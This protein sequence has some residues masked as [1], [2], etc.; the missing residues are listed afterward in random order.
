M[1]TNAAIAIIGE[2]FPVPFTQFVPTVPMGVIGAIINRRFLETPENRARMQKIDRWLA[3]DLAPILIYPIFT[4]VFMTVEPQQQMWLSLFLPILKLFLRYLLWLVIKD[5]PDLV[6]AA[7]CSVGHLYHILF[8]VMCLQN[9][10][11][12]ETYA[13]VV[14]VNIL[15]MLLNCR[16]I[17]KDAYELRRVAEQVEDLDQLGVKGIVSIVSLIALQEQISR[18][19]HRKTPS[20]LL[21]TYPEY[22]RDDY[23]T[24]YHKFLLSETY[25]IS[26]NSRLANIN[27]RDKR[28]S[29]KRHSTPDAKTSSNYPKTTKVEQWLYQALVFALPNRKYYATMATTTTFDA[30]AN[31]VFHMLVLCSLELVFLVIYMVLISSQLGY[32]GIHQLAFVLWSQRILIQGKFIMLPIMILGF[33]LAHFGN[34]IIFQLKAEV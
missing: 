22:Q 5:E 25:S 17:L 4:A 21:S 7:T 9:A 10:K 28:L 1:A 32:S 30:V 12:L 14:V 15:Q 11:S 26:Q 24:K 3:M 27:G 16:G 6:G 19:L 29:S 18:S 13:A 31:M 33:P 23:V 20:R 8:T 2:V 34:G